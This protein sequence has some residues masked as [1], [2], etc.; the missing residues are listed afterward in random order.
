MEVNY[1][2][3][4]S[5]AGMRLDHFLSAHLS[6]FSRSLISTA[7]RNGD[8]RVGG[9]RKKSSYRLKE[10]DRITGTVEVR[11]E[12]TVEPEKIDFTIIYEDQWMLALSKPPGLVVHPGSGNDKGTLVS[13]LLYH[14]SAIGGV[15]DTIR[16]GIVHRLDKDTSGL[17]VVAKTDEVHRN[18][19]SGFKERN[20]EKNYIALIHAIPL[21]R[22]GR[23]VA[24][25][26]RHPVQRQKMAVRETGGRYAATSWQLIGEIAGKYGLVKVTIE[27]GRTH[28]IRVHMAHCGHPVVGDRVYGSGR[29]NSGFLRQ[30]LHAWELIM[31]HPITG[32]KMVLRA[33]LWP[34]FQEKLK[35]LGCT[36]D[37]E[38]L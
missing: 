32:R 15:G 24:P 12:I 36:F 20:L 23:I 3:Q 8:V 14:C 18:L 37:E 6:Q 25:I 33:P 34:D 17:M 7:I 9:E 11:N 4:A 28:Q 2:V 31:C 10:N 5:H 21:E 35:Q 29:D 13:G 22:Q 16:P 1:Q 38:N 30:L 19:V 26:G 27:T